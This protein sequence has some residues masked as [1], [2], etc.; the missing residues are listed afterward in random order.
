MKKL[1]FATL[2]IAVASFAATSS[3][4][5]T[6]RIREESQTTIQTIQPESLTSFTIQPMEYDALLVENHSAAYKIGEPISFVSCQKG[7]HCN[8]DAFE[9][10]CSGNGHYSATN[11]SYKPLLA[12]GW[13][14]RILC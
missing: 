3:I 13:N 14:K 1:F 2:L 6:D 8:S 5:S 11:I 7:C 12:R 10:S 4:K 9:R